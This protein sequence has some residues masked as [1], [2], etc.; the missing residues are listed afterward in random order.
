MPAETLGTLEGKGEEP[1]RESESLS[2]LAF[3]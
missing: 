2:R 3:G 1:R